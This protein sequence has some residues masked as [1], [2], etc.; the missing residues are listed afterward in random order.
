MNRS[1]A[2]VVLVTSFVDVWGSSAS[3]EEGKPTTSGPRVRVTAPGFAKKPIVGTL[4][5]VDDT[6]VTVQRSKESENVAIARGAL[7]QFEISRKSSR[8]GKGAGIGALAGAGVGA[9]IGFAAGEDC[10]APD[11][12]SIVCFSRGASAVGVG[13]AG[14]VVGSIVGV[15][16]APGE[17][18]ETANPDSLKIN[19][20]LLRGRRGGVGFMLSLRF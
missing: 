6:T 5:A 11:A 20:T 4:T 18:W 7:T 16:V 8:K 15:I 17:K 3:A 2:I 12:P 9:A 1:L 19:V 10:G 13:L 14:A